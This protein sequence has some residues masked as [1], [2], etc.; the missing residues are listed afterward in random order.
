VNEIHPGNYIFHDLQMHA[1]NV[2]E[3]DKIAVSVLS[4]VV[5]SYPSRNRILIDAGALA[6]SKDTEATNYFGRIKG[7]PDLVVKKVS[8]E[9][10]IIEAV[11]GTIP[12]NELKIGTTVEVLPIHSCLSAACFSHYHI[13][14]DGKVQRIIQ[15]TRCW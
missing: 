8:Q 9:H 7:Y 13:V 11:N 14:Q 10:G 15:P 12:F 5:G 1:R 2:C 3:Q 6:L 4:T